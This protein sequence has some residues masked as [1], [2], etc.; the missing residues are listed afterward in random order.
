MEGREEIHSSYVE[1]VE[2]LA[3]LIQLQR[4]AART[5]GKSVCGQLAF[6]RGRAPPPLGEKAG[7]PLRFFGGKAVRHQPHLEKPQLR[8]VTQPPSCSRALPHSGQVRRAWVGRW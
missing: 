6:C 8:Q 2:N 4:K 7:C 1:K 5:P 3:T